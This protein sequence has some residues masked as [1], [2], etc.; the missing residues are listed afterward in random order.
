MIPHG[1][2]PSKLGSAVRQLRQWRGL[3][4][5]ELARK[6]GVTSN[7]VSLLENGKR[8]LSIPRLNRLAKVLDVPAIIITFLGTEVNVPDDHPLAKVTFSLQ[9]LMRTTFAFL[10]AQ[11]ANGRATRLK[12]GNGDAPSRIPARSSHAV[13]SVRRKTSGRLTAR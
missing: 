13:S 8:G 6:L 12:S 5:L 3:T 10:T 1:I 9:R 4:Q 11:H 7:Y 2:E